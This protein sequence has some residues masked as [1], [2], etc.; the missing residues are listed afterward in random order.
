M[1]HL[2][3][4][5]EDLSTL[6]VQPRSLTPVSPS[7]SD[8]LTTVEPT[9]PTGD[10]ELSRLVKTPDASVYNDSDSDEGNTRHRWGGRDE[11]Q[12]TVRPLW[13]IVDSVEWSAHLQLSAHLYNAHVLKKEYPYGAAGERRNEEKEVP[14]NWRR[15]IKNQWTAWPLETKDVP[16]EHDH[17]PGK[18]NALGRKGVRSSQRTV[19]TTRGK[20]AGCTAPSGMLEEMLT[21]LVMRKAKERIRVEKRDEME[22]A[23]DDGETKRLVL[24]VVR[25]IISRLDTLLVGLHQEREHYVKDLIPG[26][27][28]KYK[29]QKTRAA[30]REGSVDPDAPNDDDDSSSSSQQQGKKRKRGRATPE[31]YAHYLRNRWRRVR[32]RDWSQVMGMAGIKG[33]EQAPLEETAK[34]CAKLFGQDMKFRTLGTSSKKGTVWTAIEGL[35]KPLHSF[36]EGSYLE[37]VTLNRGGRNR[38]YRKRKREPMKEKGGVSGEGDGSESEDGQDAEDEEGRDRRR[39]NR[40]NMGASERK[41]EEDEEGE[42]DG[43]GGASEE[44]DSEASDGGGREEGIEEP[45][46]EE[47]MRPKRQRKK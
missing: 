23:V 47:E 43:E 33:W 39:R 9:S 13:R 41:P 36:A 14:E 11:T 40:R 42:R 30:A 10:D 8:C 18:V 38:E 28:A 19:G 22:P 37:E 5:G 32:P 3:I 26:G 45:E 35:P 44:E 6:P 25:N 24:P 16:R 7:N 12:A 2:S 31:N 4:F 46:D 34:R 17:M 27:D 15:F 21:V 20:G 29:W 1:S